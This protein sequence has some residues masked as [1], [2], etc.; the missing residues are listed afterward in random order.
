MKLTRSVLVLLALALLIAPDASAAPKKPSKT[1]ISIVASRLLYLP[2]QIGGPY[3]VAT[4]V[5]RNKSRFQAEGV[6]GQVSVYGP[7]RKLLKTFQTNRV[8]IPPRGIAVLSEE[9]LKLPVANDGGAMRLHIRVDRFV[10]PRR[11]AAFPLS[12][13]TYRKSSDEF[14]LDTCSV[15]GVIRNVSKKEADNVRV[16]VA[17][18]AGGRVITSTSEFIDDLLPGLPQTF[19]AGFV[20][21][22]ECPDAVDGIVAT[23]QSMF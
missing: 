19:D 16:I 14:S 22:A 2:D 13:L 5:L 17:T 21:P 6:G 4:F 10:K 15:S 3:H 23:G 18:Y 12:G 11:A 1:A 20:S 8:T 9:A 7:G